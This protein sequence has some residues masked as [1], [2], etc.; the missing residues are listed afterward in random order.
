MTFAMLTGDD[1]RHLIIAIQLGARMHGLAML[2]HPLLCGHRGASEL[3]L[4]WILSYVAAW[5]GVLFS[6]PIVKHRNRLF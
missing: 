2:R 4:A 6:M 1:F 5:D 3:H